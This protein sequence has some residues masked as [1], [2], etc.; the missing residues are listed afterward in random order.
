M[1][2]LTPQQSSR[3]RHACVEYLAG[4]HLLAFDPSQVARLAFRE[5][6]VDFEPSVDDAKDALDLLVELGHVKRVRDELGNQHAYQ[7][8]ASG[9]IARECGE[10]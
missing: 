2:A 1:S 10:I 5:R 9:R 8:S 6:L 3:L 4:R 7:I